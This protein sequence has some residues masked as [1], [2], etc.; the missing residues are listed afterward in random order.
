[1]LGQ[2]CA[3]AVV[4]WGAES[5]YFV[6]WRIHI[7]ILHRLLL[8]IHIYRRA[9]QKQRRPCH[10]MQGHEAGI[11]VLQAMLVVLNRLIM[12]Y[13]LRPTLL[14][15]VSWRVAAALAH[16]NINTGLQRR[17]LVPPR[18]LSIVWIVLNI[19][20]AHRMRPSILKTQLVPIP[21]CTLC[22]RSFFFFF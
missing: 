5:I 15:I 22:L 21:S 14:V 1:M 16:I 19:F 18:R 11:A 6:D 12:I 3:R 20:R 8:I 10:V 9:L 2:Q 13:R 4:L 17:C 7:L